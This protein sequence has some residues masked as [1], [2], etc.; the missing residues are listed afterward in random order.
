MILLPPEQYQPQSIALFNA[1]AARIKAILPQARIEHV[2][3]SSIPGAI[4]KGDLDLCVIVR[5]EHF[6]AALA[7]LQALGYTVKADTLRTSQLCMLVPDAPDQDHAIQLLEAGSRFEFFV[8]FR[9]TLR[10]NPD[11]LRR[12]NELKQAAAMLGADAYRQAKGEFIDQ[13]VTAVAA[14]TDG[15]PRPTGPVRPIE[16][17]AIYLNPGFI[18]APDLLFESLKQS[19]EWDQRMRARKTASFGVPYNYSQ[20]AYDAAPMPQSLE[21]ICARIALELGFHP[22]NCLLNYYPDGASSMGFHSDSTAELA[23][24]TGVAIVSIGSV[25]SMVYRSKADKT[26]QFE[27][28]LQNG[29]LLYM[30]GQ[31]QQEWLHAIPKAQGAGERISLTFRNI[32]Q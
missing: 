6:A 22:N 9:D 1:L 21:A 7:A 19:V 20:I 31:I 30:S 27:Y 2:G 5:P 12:Y 25:R 4:S 8:V 15:K 23:P 17:P 11:A 26:V 32:I 24:G 28:P 29:S 16:P 13:I 3:A 18:D 14:T 10:T